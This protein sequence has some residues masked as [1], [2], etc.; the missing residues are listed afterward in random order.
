MK[1]LYFQKALSYR[2]QQFQEHEQHHMVN[3]ERGGGYAVQTQ[4]G[5]N[6][7]GKAYTKHFHQVEFREKLRIHFF[8]KQE[9]SE[10]SDSST[11]LISL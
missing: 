4:N 5:L 3:E 6:L 9:C 1:I 2:I 7:C 8:W 11:N 10:H